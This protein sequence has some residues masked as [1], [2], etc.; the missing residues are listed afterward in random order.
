MRAQMTETTVRMFASILAALFAWAAIAK[1]IGAKQWRAALDGYNL[2][3]SIARG[4]AVATPIAEAAVAVVLVAAPLRIGGALA[5]GLLATFS[6]ALARVAMLRGP[7]VPC[8][9]FGANKERE[10]TTMLARNAVIG[11][12]A[13]IVLV[14][15]D[16]VRLISGLA[17]PRPAD[18]VPLVLAVVGLGLMAALLRATMAMRGRR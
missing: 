10:V 2:P 13:V 15:G 9:C 5:L 12:V 18:A 14:V 16:D 7:R 8:G 6:L 17:A 4:A 1:A 3:R 11:A